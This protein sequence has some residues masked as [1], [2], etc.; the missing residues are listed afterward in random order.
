MRTVRHLVLSDVHGNV[1]ALRAVLDAVS[2][3]RIDRVLCLGDL[4]GYGPF[5]NECVAAVAGL[6]AIT[7]AGN[8]DLI[9]IGELSDERCGPL[10]RRTT[11]W[12]RA[13]LDDGTRR[14]LA[15]LPRTTRVDGVLLAHGSIEDPQ[16]YVRGVER[17]TDELDRMERDEPGCLVLLLGHTHQPWAFGP[18]TGTLLRGPRSA[19]VVLDAAQPHLVNPGS[20]GQSRDRTVAARFV[21]LDTDRRTAEFRSVPYDVQ[22]HTDALR[23]A[24]LPAGSH[25]MVPTV[26]DRMVS[27]RWTLL[28]RARRMGRRVL[29]GSRWR[30]S[31]GD[32]TSRD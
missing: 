12:T 25:R 11:A 22:G 26:R 21:V 17:A 9:A 14:Y 8:H 30:P 29:G 1:H 24:G 5:P 27:A 18:V 23:A 6:D 19:G 2:G 28:G 10:A 16:Q 20:V 3:E 32:D 31:R 7:V 13:A 4:V 15:A